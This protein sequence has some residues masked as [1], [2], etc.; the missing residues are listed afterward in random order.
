MH[1]GLGTAQ[2]RPLLIRL[3]QAVRAVT[4]SRAGPGVP[5]RTLP[6]DIY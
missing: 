5:P 2:L 1:K 4:G 6:A 3:E